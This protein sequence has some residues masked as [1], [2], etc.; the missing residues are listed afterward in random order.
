MDENWQAVSK[1]NRFEFGFRNLDVQIFFAELIFFSDAMSSNLSQ[2]KKT[3]FV[4]KEEI[5]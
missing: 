1:K 5:S 2:V 3:I 4:L